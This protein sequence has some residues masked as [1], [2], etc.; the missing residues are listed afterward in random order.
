[1]ACQVEDLAH[2]QVADYMT[3]D[4]FTLQ[5]HVPI[6]HALHL[7]SNHGFRHL[8]LVDDQHRPDGMIS[9]RDVVRYLKAD[10]T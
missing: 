2:A 5:A 9:F 4:P 7:M 6:K 3:R 10:L 1:V 8:P